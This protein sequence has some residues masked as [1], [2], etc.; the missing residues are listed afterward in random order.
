MSKIDFPF[1][2]IPRY[3]ENNG[4]F[5]PTKK[6]THA[7]A[8]IFIY[9]CF[10][11]TRSFERTIFHDYRQVVL[12]PFQFIFGINVCSRETGLSLQNIKTLVNQLN[13]IPNQ[14]ILKKATNSVTN[15]FTVYEWATSLFSENANQLS[16]QLLTNSS[17]TVQP[18]T[19]TKK[20]EQ[21]ETI[22]NVKEKKE[23]LIASSVFVPF[24][25][26]LLEK[27][28]QEELELPK[29]GMDLFIFC[30][31]RNLKVTE[32]TLNVW[33]R[34]YPKPFIEET[35][36]YVSKQK[37]VK[38]F[39]KYMESSLKSRWAITSKN[40]EINR[41]FANK[42]L[43]ENKWPGLTITKS[44]ITNHSLSKD[45]QFNLDPVMFEM[46]LKQDYENQIG[47]I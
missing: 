23:E 32:Q 41:A 9:W 16:N 19:R 30:A 28:I 15:R 33:I 4:W 1:V 46:M 11:R 25:S 10:S 27:N 5:I 44:Y 6:L 40:Q 2:F 31:D 29:L 14:E 43:L 38:S 36:I 45:Y 13:R 17:P 3:F 34:K 39:E 35:L 26:F 24:D 8:M 7:Q 12:K 42:F 20:K 37:N 18:Q 22:V 47:E 21:K